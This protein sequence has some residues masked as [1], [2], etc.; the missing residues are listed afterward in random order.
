MP[1]DLGTAQEV[2][3]SNDPVI[4]PADDYEIFPHSSEMLWE[5]LF[6]TGLIEALD[7]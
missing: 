7:Y 2:F 1:K 5:Q 3:S 6:R 4:R